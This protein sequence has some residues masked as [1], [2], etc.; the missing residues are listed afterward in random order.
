MYRTFVLLLIVALGAVA[1]LQETRIAGLESRLVAQ[2]ERLSEIQVR[3]QA[4]GDVGG[5]FAK[6]IL[7]N[8]KTILDLKRSREVTVTAYSPRMRETDSTPYLTASNNPV[9]QGIVAVSRDLFDSGWVFG[10]KIYLKGLGM[11]TIDDLMAPEKRNQID[12]FMYDTDSAL[13]FGK[14]TLRASLLDS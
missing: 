5:L 14:R 6:L 7:D 2:G 4:S 1:W 9:R 10:R 11:F 13:G 8:R 3:Q 12:I